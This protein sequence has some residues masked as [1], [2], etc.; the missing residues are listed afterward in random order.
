MDL[1]LR[2]VLFM[3]LLFFV[4]AL[5]LVLIYIYCY[6][7]YSFWGNLGRCKLSLGFYKQLNNY[8]SVRD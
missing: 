4:W 7:I 6:S 8:A 2:K 1:F 3:D 5:F